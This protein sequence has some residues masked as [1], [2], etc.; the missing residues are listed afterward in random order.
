MS[1]VLPWDGVYHIR[2][3]A[4]FKQKIGIKDDIVAGRHEDSV[5]PHIEWEIKATSVGD[6]SKMTIK[7]KSYSGSYYIGVDSEKTVCNTAPYEWNVSFCGT[8]KWIIRDPASGLLLCMLDGD[9]GTKV[10]FTKDDAGEV[11]YWRFI[12]IRPPLN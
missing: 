9:D 3:A 12:P 7:S 5:D 4:H 11:S 6:Y 1:F 8:G 2:S 10:E